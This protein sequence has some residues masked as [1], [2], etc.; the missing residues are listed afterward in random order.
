MN[1]L[2]LSHGTLGGSWMI[3]AQSLSCS[4]GHIITG[5]ELHE[6]FFTHISRPLFGMTGIIAAAPVATPLD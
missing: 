5:L 3:S 6:D 2:I 1:S 4:C